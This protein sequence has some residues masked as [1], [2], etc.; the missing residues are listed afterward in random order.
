MAVISEYEEESEVKPSPPP[1][2]A[3]AA[4]APEVSGTSSPKG[5]Y[6]ESLGYLLEQHNGKPFELF[7]SVVEF[8]ARKTD[9]LSSQD[10]DSRLQEI[11]ASVKAKKVMKQEAPSVTTRAAPQAE[12]KPEPLNQPQV[13]IKPTDQNGAKE[14]K[15]SEPKSDVPSSAEP[16]DEDEDSKSKGIVPNTGNGA[17]LEKYTW[18]QTLAEVTVHIPLPPG[19]KSRAVA[20]EIKKKHLKVGLKGQ[21]PVLEGEL[22][23]PITVDDSLWSIEDGK[24]LAVLLT[25]SNQM[26]W[27]KSVVKGEPEIDTQKVEPENSKLGDLDPETRQTVEKM[28]YDQRQKAMG[29]PTSEEK[30]KQ[31]I[32]KKFMAQHPEMDFSKA[33]MC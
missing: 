8:L 17:D 26:E 9:V 22:F 14:S 7:R 33:K 29:L 15:V 24:T 28:M 1:A 3:R 16:M 2:T 5:K 23:N 6:D 18:T 12:K 4:P 25:K 11:V 31:D 27:W 32:L 10:F 19:T 20:C 21:P 30:Q 13:N